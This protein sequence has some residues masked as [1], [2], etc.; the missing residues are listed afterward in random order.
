MV[1]LQRSA[2]IQSQKNWFVLSGSSWESRD[3][4]SPEQEECHRKGCTLLLLL[5]GSS[6]THMERD[7]G[8]LIWPPLEQPN[9]S[10]S[11]CGPGPLL[12]S[13]LVW[14]FLG[15]WAGYCPC[16]HIGWCD[17]KDLL[18]E[19]LTSSPSYAPGAG[20]GRWPLGDLG[21]VTLSFPSLS[22][23]WLDEWVSCT[24]LCINI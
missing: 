2:Q 21:L 16:R 14:G 8:Q 4:L 13:P 5:P 12:Q 19:A 24:F 1:R 6:Q 7:K 22:W 18:W 23:K 3:R 17:D 15:L 9:L 10:A 11:C 20:S